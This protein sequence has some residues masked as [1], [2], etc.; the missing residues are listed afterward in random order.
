MN[1][2]NRKKRRQ[3]RQRDLENEVNTY[4]VEG[5]AEHRGG[6]FRVL[7]KGTKEQKRGLSWQQATDLW[8]EWGN[9]IILED[10]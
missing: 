6:T 1:N 2:A 9:S 5:M 8:R 4:G 3:R 7:N 10:K